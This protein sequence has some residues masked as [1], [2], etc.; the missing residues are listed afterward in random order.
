MQRKI[1]SLKMIQNFCGEPIF[2]RGMEYYR[3]NKFYRPY[4]YNDCIGGRCR[5]SMGHSYRVEIIFDSSSFSNIKELYCSCPTE[6]YYVC[7]QVA[8]AL[9]SFCRHPDY[10]KQKKE[11]EMILM[12]KSKKWIV[13]CILDYACMNKNVSEYIIKAATKGKRKTK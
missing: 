3:Q 5:G 13:D 4:R 8:A 10:F 7:K 2:S 12:K 1:I 11:I 6:H 9:I